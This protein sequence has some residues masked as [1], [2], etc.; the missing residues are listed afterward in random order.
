[1]DYLMEKGEM[2]YNYEITNDSKKIDKKW[3]LPKN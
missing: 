2:G 3:L 1:M